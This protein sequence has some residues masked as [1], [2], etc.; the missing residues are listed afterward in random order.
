[1]LTP[2]A[3]NSGVLHS[4][5]NAAGFWKA[6]WKSEAVGRDDVGDDTWE[7]ALAQ[8]RCIRGLEEETPCSS[9]ADV[10]AMM[11][12]AGLGAASVACACP[13]DCSFSFMRLSQ[14]RSFK[15]DPSFLECISFSRSSQH[16]A[17]T[18]VP[19]IPPPHVLG[20]RPP[21]SYLPMCAHAQ[22]PAVAAHN[23]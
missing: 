19:V 6:L 3:V 2:P 21:S 10:Q 23:L 20:S 4:I 11:L 17:V 13:S 12:R 8:L 1:M 14:R 15:V 5:V 22:Q 18:C 7:H 9:A 16:I